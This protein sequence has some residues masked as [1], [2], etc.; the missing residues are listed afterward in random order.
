[1]L[2]IICTFSLLFCI[3]ISHAQRPGGSNGKKGPKSEKIISGKIID[4]SS[5][6]ALEFATISILS[7]KDSTILG[8][9][10]TGPDG[11]FKI[12]TKGRRI[13]ATI[14]FIGFETK[15]IDPIPLEKGKKE[16]A[17]GEITLS[18]SNQIL[19]DVQVT[20][21][22]S[23]TVFKLDKKVFNVGRD[24]ASKGGSAE[25]VLD[26]VPS[27]SVDIEG[28]V[29]LRGSSN[30]R[31][32]VD[33]KPSGLIG[34]SSTNGLKAISAD[35]IEKIEVITNPSARYEAEGNAGIINI[36]MKKNRKKGINGTISGTIGTPT[37]LGLGL[38]LNYR[39]NKLNFFTNYNINSRDRNGKSDIYQE[40]FG[41]PSLITLTNRIFDRPSKTQSIRFGADYF[42]S[43]KDVLTAS[44]LYKYEKTQSNAFIEYKDYNG[45]VT[46]D[47]LFNNNL[48]QQ[49]EEEKSP[50]LEYSINYR[51]EF[52][53][54]D[55]VFDFVI[56]FSESNEQEDANFFE[57]D[58]LTPNNPRLN[59][60]RSSIDEG[61]KKW[62]FQTD[63]VNP[64]QNEA[65]LEMGLRSSIRNIKNNF[66]VEENADGVWL[67]LENVSNDFRYDENIHAAYLMY[68]NKINQ[69]SFQVGA[70]AE[71]SHVITEL[72]ST[73]EV[74]DRKYLDLFP[75]A[76][77]NYELS[78]AASWQVSYSRRIKRPRFW[79]LNPFFTFADD[80]NR[81]GGNPNLDPEYANAYEV[82]YLRFWDKASLSGSL[83]YRYTSGLI[84]RISTLLSD[85]T[86]L[87]LPENLSSAENYGLEVN[88]SYTALKWWKLN[89]SFNFFRQITDGQN[90]GETFVS[91][92][93]SWFSKV[94]SRF[95]FWENTE[96][97]LRGN[98]RAP[99]E[100]TQGK[101][102]GILSVDLGLSKDFLK[103][104]L[105][106]TFGVR[107]IFDSRKR[108]RELF[109]DNRYS[110]S[111]FQRSSRT[112]TLTLSYKLS[113]ERTKGRKQKRNTG[114]DS[115][116]GF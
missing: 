107:D 35:A 17:L 45:V 47:S 38:N 84:E 18:S 40:I 81:F 88:G 77:L 59:T 30:V 109:A 108:E 75:S 103:R 36:V 54:K 72:V 86:T 74:N 76:H 8:G 48:R 97:Q 92:D 80:R 13:F 53:E 70:R 105:S 43:D 32:L 113:K 87:F 14:D 91:D 65:V 63:F 98:Y 61:E 89:G 66:L 79:F 3:A 112:A 96:L 90:F 29:S 28:N 25:D 64:L 10:I 102:A 57:Q 104:R 42:F 20:S 95:T 46:T 100:T 34:I 15:V 68:G 83:Y 51:K 41:E 67:N 115:D 6:Q 27:V 56:Q 12:T 82:S 39:A 2:R 23:E 116:E 31:I 24:L 99:R 7:K 73:D 5:K 16:C 58:I 33:G 71:W 52:E 9:A 101:N 11:M 1:M 94:T 62:L 60:E 49:E 19:N 4:A 55:K 78:E 44:L 93:Y 106:V 111:S 110:K 37:I 50:V 85:G 26:N 22:R 69:F 21:A 114:F